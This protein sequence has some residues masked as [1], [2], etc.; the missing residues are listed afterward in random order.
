MLTIKKNDNIFIKKIHEAK[1][2]GKMVYIL[3]AANG[4]KRIANGLKY[5][6]I[7]IDA[8]IVDEEY[9][10]PGEKM[11]GV[12]VLNIETVD[13]SKAIIII[14]VAN[15][16]KLSELKKRAYIIDEDI[17]SLSMAASPPFD[18]TFI[19][20][21][22][23]EFNDLYEKL[24]DRKSRQVMNAYLNQKITG[25]FCELK[26][27]WNKLQYFDGDF[28]DLSKVSCIVDCG[29]FDGDSFLSFCSAYNDLTGNDF[30]GD[31]YLLDPDTDNQKKIMN[32]CRCCVANVMQLQVGA[33]HEQ[34]TM[35][36]QTD[37][38]FGT[39]GKITLSNVGNVIVKVD[40]I[41][42]ILQGNRVDF[43]KMDIEGAELNALRG[44]K[45]SI[46]KYHPVLAV[47]AY[48]KRE[49]LLELPRYISSLCSK[50]KF[51]IRAYG[52]PY[53]IELVLFAVA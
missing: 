45:E 14:S 20:K 26:G 7:D 50:Y 23:M 34:G 31:A 13:L 6:N 52:G 44:A 43:I 48:H 3:G 17:Q 53:S 51:Y 15:Y 40:K 2:E 33:W 18:H 49:D 42:N 32:N 11:Q 12:E 10:T 38:R 9:Y 29:A 39:A 36:F 21:H 28:Y 27:L 22:F 47:C 16:P 30:V 1:Q 46:I 25:R 24:A 4:G 8:F 35:S 37:F 19:S 41:D 5:F